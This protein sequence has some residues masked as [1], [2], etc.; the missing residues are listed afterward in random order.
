MKLVLYTWY[1]IIYYL[2]YN[3]VTS[4]TALLH[5]DLSDG[6]TSS[7]STLVRVSV[8]EVVVGSL[9]HHGRVDVRSKRR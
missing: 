6:S 9:L 7:D 3:T 2:V 5:A 4:L 8:L 1:I